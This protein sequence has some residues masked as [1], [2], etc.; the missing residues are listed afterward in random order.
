MLK[1]FLYLRLK[2]KVLK[3]HQS[4]R[5]KTYLETVL[6]MPIFLVMFFVWTFLSDV[7]PTFTGLWWKHGKKQGLASLLYI[8]C[9]TRNC[10]FIHDFFTSTK[11]NKCFEISQKI[12]YTMRSLSLGHEGI[13]KFNTLMNI[14]KPM[15]VRITIKLFLE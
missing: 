12:V 13:N 6:L 14:P 5:R 9:A 4:I 8:K 7:W 10:R 3:W 1:N 15:T 2:F 11:V